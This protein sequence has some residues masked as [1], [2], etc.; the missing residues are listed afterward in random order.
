MEWDRRVWTALRVNSIELEEDRGMYC[1]EPHRGVSRIHIVELTNCWSGS[2][3]IAPGLGQAVPHD[4]RQTIHTASLR[5]P[6]RVSKDIYREPHIAAHLTSSFQS[7][8]NAAFHL[9]I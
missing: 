9:D 6:M 1:L 3:I 8:L 7:P 5:P 4:S 2:T